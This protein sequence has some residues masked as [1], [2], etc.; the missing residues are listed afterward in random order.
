M[1]HLSRALCLPKSSAHRLLAALR[2]RGLVEQVELSTAHGVVWRISDHDLKT[3][4]SKGVATADGAEKP[5]VT[6]LSHG[7]VDVAK[8]AAV[9]VE[10]ASHADTT[11]T[12]QCSK[13]NKHNTL[14]VIRLSCNLYK[15]LIGETK[16]SDLEVR[17][18]KNQ[19]YHSKTIRTRF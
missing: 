5:T 12:S 7:A 6:V 2:R 15:R 16:F 9:C 18:T 1:S 4:D 11:S 8:S 10:K 17:I 14:N 13:I 19:S 3:L